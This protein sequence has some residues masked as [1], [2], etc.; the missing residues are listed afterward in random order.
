MDEEMQKYAMHNNDG[1]SDGWSA[2]VSGSDDS[3]EDE[4]K[5]RIEKLDNENVDESAEIQM[6]NSLNK[7]SEMQAIRHQ[8][9]VLL[10][11]LEQS[12]EREDMLKQEIEELKI[13]IQNGIASKKLKIKEEE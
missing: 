5:E 1:I 9:D 7:K 2:D 6:Q 11:R 4:V 10:F 12:E 8:N 3:I 13:V